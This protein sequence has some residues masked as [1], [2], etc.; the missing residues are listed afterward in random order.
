MPL[1]PRCPEA[2]INSLSTPL[3]LL[4]YVNVPYPTYA[5]FNEFGVRYVRGDVSQRGDGFPEAW[6]KWTA[7]D[8]TREAL[9]NL[10]NFM[11]G[12]GSASGLVYIRTRTNRNDDKVYQNFSAW[13]YLPELT[14]KDGSPVEQWIDAYTNVNVHF[15]GLVAL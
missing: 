6:W 11:G 14:G 7:G 10:V 2:S 15:A 9:N 5:P 12:W 8:I 3:Y 1:Y 13:M 4:P